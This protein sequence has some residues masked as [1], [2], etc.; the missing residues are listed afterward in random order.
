[1]TRP[2]LFFF[3]LPAFLAAQTPP[4]E[5]SLKLA[6]IQQLRRAHACDGLDPLKKRISYAYGPN[7][8]LVSVKG[9]ANETFRFSYDAQ[10]NLT[11][12]KQPDGSTI[13]R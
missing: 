6:V 5:L 12:I 13:H 9:L 3:L 10:H 2:A 7:G 4:L 11:T 8:D 1:M